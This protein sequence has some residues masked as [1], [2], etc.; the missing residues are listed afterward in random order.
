M[1]NEKDLLVH[2]W[3]LQLDDDHQ[4]SFSSRREA[5]KDKEPLNGPSKIN[6]C[7]SQGEVPLFISY[8]VLIFFN[9]SCLRYC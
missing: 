6:F 2:V 9:N 3:V 5:S 4:R 8:I 7:S 1:F